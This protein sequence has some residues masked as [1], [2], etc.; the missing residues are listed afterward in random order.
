MSQ[1]KMLKN[2]MEFNA[3]RKTL[4]EK[5]GYFPRI[6]IMQYVD[7]NYLCTIVRKKQDG[8]W[9]KFPVINVFFDTGKS[10]ETT[11]VIPIVQRLINEAYMAMTLTVISDKIV[12]VNGE[13]I[14]IKDDCQMDEE[15]R[16]IKN[17]VL[18]HNF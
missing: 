18:N 6:T 1:Q 14:F 12:D 9:Y 10:V 17:D 5:S 16:L 15:E 8:I 2:N 11:G 3:I 7:T 13:S 4:I